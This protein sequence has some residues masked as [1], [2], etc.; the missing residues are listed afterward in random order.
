MS[1]EHP[2][3]H[4]DELAC[5]ELV[6]IVTDYLEGALGE[7]ERERFEAHLAQCSFCIDYVEQMRAVSAAL[8]AGAIRRETLD[9]ERRDAL[10][11]AFRDWSDR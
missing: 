5:R 2:H 8:G 7:D 4:G 10:L 9:P 1:S 11:D 3:H 6:E